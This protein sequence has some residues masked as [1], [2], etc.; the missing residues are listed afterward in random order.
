MLNGRLVRLLVGEVDVVAKGKFKVD[1]AG[2]MYSH[3]HARHQEAP[4]KYSFTSPRFMN[5]RPRED[6]VTAK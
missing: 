5:K 4:A 2:L 6:K 3:S 1:S